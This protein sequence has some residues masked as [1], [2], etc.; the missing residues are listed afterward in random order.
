MFCGGK[1]ILPGAYGRRRYALLC[2]LIPAAG[3]S[4]PAWPVVEQQ[5]ATKGG[6]SEQGANS[7]IVSEGVDAMEGCHGHERERAAALRLQDR[8]WAC[9]WQEKLCTP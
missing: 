8:A 3:G 7:G 9:L 6:E 5:G 4:A 1:S 2:H